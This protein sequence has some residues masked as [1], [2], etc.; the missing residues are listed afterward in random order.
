MPFLKPKLSWTGALAKSSSHVLLLP[1]PLFM[2][3]KGSGTLALLRL[4]KPPFLLPVSQV[5]PSLAELLAGIYSLWN[6]WFY[7]KQNWKKE[8]STPSS[9][10]LNPF[11]GKRYSSWSRCEVRSLIMY[12][13]VLSRPRGPV[14][15]VFLGLRESVQLLE[16]ELR[17]TASAILKHVLTIRTFLLSPCIYPLKFTLIIVQEYFKDQ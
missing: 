12:H 3:G 6:V 13:S 9:S 8:A 7:Y 10:Y 5:L 1:T 17:W 11:Q 15:D 2:F 4:Q 14:L 16:A